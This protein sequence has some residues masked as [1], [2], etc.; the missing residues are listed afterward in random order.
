M[1]QMA[2]QRGGRVCTMDDRFCIDNGAMIAWAG[3]LMFRR[4]CREIARELLV[5]STKKFNDDITK[6]LES[7]RDTD[8]GVT[9]SVINL[10]Q[11]HVGSLCE[12]GLGDPLQKLRVTQRFRTDEVECVWRDD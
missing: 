8:I 3:L 2:E 7:A 10:L 5:D 1:S 9:S 6:A 11:L 12:G 4:Q